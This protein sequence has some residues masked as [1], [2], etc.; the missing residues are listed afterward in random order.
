MLSKTHKSCNIS[1]NKH[2]MKIFRLL[3]FQ[4]NVLVTLPKNC[5]EYWVQ[6]FFNFT[7]VNAYQV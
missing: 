3:E 6:L 5:L 4:L 7:P 2:N 1:Q